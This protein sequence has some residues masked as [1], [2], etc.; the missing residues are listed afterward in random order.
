MKNRLKG[1]SNAKRV[2]IGKLMEAMDAEI[3]KAGYEKGFA[4]GQ[5]A[6][7][8]VEDTAVETIGHE[9]K[10]L[11]KVDREAREGDFARFSV[12]QANLTVDI[13]PGKLYEV[14]SYKDRLAFECDTH[15]TMP[16]YL[17]GKFGRNPGN[18]EVF[19]V[20]GGVDYAS[21]ESFSSDTPPTANQQ[22]AELIQRAR[23]FAE[24]L[25]DKNHDGYLIKGKN[26]IEFLCYAKYK[27]NHSKRTTT[28]TLV[29]IGSGY[30]RK[31]ITT[32]CHPNEVFNESIGELISLYKA[33]EI[34]IPQEFMEA[35][36]PDDFV[37]GMVV[38]DNVF[39]YGK[40][41][42]ID[43]HDSVRDGLAHLGSPCM[44]S[45]IIID[46]TNA[47]YASGNAGDSE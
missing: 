9:G 25:I 41:T 27:H 37:V 20:V 32:K 15:A 35:V 22:R 10:L 14:I 42:V 2:E 31:K 4:D 6:S 13:T 11:K 26:G 7:S 5:A 21:G 29:G 43:N 24:G 44:D 47:D 34:D 38:M 23:E 18:V 8:T 30:T 1:L 40:L 39:S 45:A 46:D 3:Y 28:C 16:Y 19:E 36:Q 12:V 33:L 17:Y